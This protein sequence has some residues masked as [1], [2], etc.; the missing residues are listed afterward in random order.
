LGAPDSTPGQYSHDATGFDSAP[1]R[2]QINPFGTALAASRHTGNG[3]HSGG[4]F[5]WV[6]VVAE[7]I[8]EAVALAGSGQGTSVMTRS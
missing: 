8:A 2:T 4:Y 7:Q 3:V 1:S 5:V 6:G